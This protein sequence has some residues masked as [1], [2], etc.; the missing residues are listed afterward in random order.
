MRPPDGIRTMLTCDRYGTYSTSGAVNAGLDL[1]MPGPT[2][3]RGG[4]LQHV[5]TANKIRPH[6][7]DQ[8]VRAVLDIVKVTAKSGVPEGVPEKELNRPQ[9]RESLRRFASE[10]IVLLKNEGRTKN[11]GNI[12]PLNHNRKVAVIGPNAKAEVFSGGGSASL[13]PYYVVTPYQGIKNQCEDVQFSQG[14]YNHKELPLLG[15]H[16]RTDDGKVGFCVHT[17]DKPAGAKD[18]KLLDKLHQTNSYMYVVDYDVPNHNGDLFYMDVE[19]TFTPE[20]DS[21][22]DFGLTVQGTGK[23]FIDN[24][25]LVDNTDN[26]RPGT[27]FFGAAT[28]EEIGSVELVAGRT[29]KIFVEFGTAPTAKPIDR[30]TV[31]FGA[32]GLRLGMCKQ[33]EPEKAISDAVKLA[34]EVDQVVV[35]AGLNNDWESEGFDRPDMDLPPHS[36]ELISRVLEAN[37]DA[38]IC[39][40]SGTP[41]TMPWIEK[42]N[43]V[44]QAWYGGNE[45]GNGIADVLF[46]SVNPV[47]IFKSPHRFSC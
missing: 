23:L 25:L 33:L 16:M 7:L 35:F 29:Y 45:T 18:R 6:V 47:S 3:W 10:S 31:S 11:G 42:A 5:V 41:V 27:A 21:V 2:R 22:Y 39:I 38:V 1:E 34:A 8:R 24:K 15:K 37:P 26:Q 46:A 40:Q 14:A 44:V 36:D 13:L 4:A 19:G 17:Y 32:G 30:A 12:L 43:A 20:A 9:D 28:V